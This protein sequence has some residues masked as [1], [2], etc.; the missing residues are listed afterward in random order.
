MK[1]KIENKITEI[2]DY[3][4]S[5]DA[6]HISYNEYRILDSKLSSIKYEEESKERNKH[7]AEMMASTFAGSFS[8]SK[9]LPEPSEE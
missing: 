5:K 6:K 2:I 4:T 8:G 3:I 9:P 1:E 7:F